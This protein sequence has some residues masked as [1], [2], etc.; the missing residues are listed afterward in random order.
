MAKFEKVNVTAKQVGKNLNIYVG[1]EKFTIVGD[2]DKLQPYKDA[3]KAYLDKPT[4]ANHKMLMVGLKPVTVETEKKVEETKTAIKVAKGKA[5][6]AE[7]TTPVE[8]K[9]DKKVSKGKKNLLSKVVDSVGKG[10]DKVKE[11]LT[12][13]K[14]IPQTKAYAAPTKRRGEY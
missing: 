6:Q 11:S 14:S 5:K 1:E 10:V 2:K 9:K 8:E 3:I 4:Q 13:A 12:A 7:K